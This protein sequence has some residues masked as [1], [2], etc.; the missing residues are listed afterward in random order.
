[1]LLRELSPSPLNPV[2]LQEFADH[3][4][5]AHGF[6]DDIAETAL[7]ELYL[8]N[9]TSVVETRLCRALINRSYVL[10]LGSWDRNGYLTLPV[11]PVASIDSFKFIDATGSIDVASDVWVLEPGKVRQRL[12]G[13]GGSALP[14]IP[15]SA[16]VELTF[17]GG[18][19]ASWSDVPGDLRQAVLLLA[20]HYYENRHGEA[21][22][23]AGLPF[24]VI[25]L[26]EY[27]RPVRL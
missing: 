22:H 21:E 12:T 26:L 4:R 17:T 11:G 8:R 1:M 25:S 20:A 14:A 10:Q 16:L 7:L 6:S 13:V 19:G 9:A 3:L 5:L 2:P 15:P 27:H 23:D 24:G 18:Y